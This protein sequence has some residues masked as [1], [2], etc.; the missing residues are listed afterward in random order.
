MNSRIIIIILSVIIAILVTVNILMFREHREA[1]F[2]PGPGPGFM[3]NG[4]G[5][6][7]RHHMQGNRFG[8]NFCSP[9]FMKEKL[10]L[11][12]EQIARIEDL[13]TKFDKETSVLFEQLK[14]EKERLKVILSESDKPDMNEVKKTL[15]RMSSLNV[16]LQLLRIRQGCDIDR[17]L[18]EEQQNTLRRERN[19]FF[20]RMQ[21]KR[22][23]RDE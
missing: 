8:R 16:E 5:M 10:N 18:T 13:N 9:D 4:P 22:G 14:P 6:P 19:M 17:I 15:E 12:S 23:G 2:M 1:P 20:E 7:G 3:D 11:S 21:R